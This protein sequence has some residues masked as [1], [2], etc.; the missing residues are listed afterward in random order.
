MI[1]EIIHQVTSNPKCGIAIQDNSNNRWVLPFS[2]LVALQSKSYNTVTD[3]L[4][5]IS[6]K[7]HKNITVYLKRTN[8]TSTDYVCKNGE[9]TKVVLRATN[10]TNLEVSE[11]TVQASAGNSAGA[12]VLANSPTKQPIM[13]ESFGLNAAQAQ[14]YGVYAKADRY[15]EAKESLSN[16]LLSAKSWEEKYHIL[17]NEFRDQSYVLKDVKK[18]L[19]TEKSKPKNFFSDKVVETGAPVLNKIVDLLSA[20]QQGG[21]AAPA[22]QIQENYSAIKTTLLNTIKDELFT[23]DYCQLYVALINK[24]VTENEFSVQL[25]K[26]LQTN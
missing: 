24:G 12:T 7:G 19:E 13:G 5:A 20:K 15:D 21:L 3:A 6:D 22:Q 25:N 2:T 14:V 11:N 23:D 10:S 9:K 16:A 4:N 17:N 26:L 8:G 18:E 1:K